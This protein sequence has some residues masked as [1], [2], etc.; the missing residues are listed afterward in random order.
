MILWTVKREHAVMLS[1][2]LRCFIERLMMLCKCIVQLLNKGA[3]TLAP[4]LD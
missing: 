4:S 1:F 3:L 2:C